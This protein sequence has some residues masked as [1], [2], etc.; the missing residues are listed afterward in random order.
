MWNIIQ[1]FPVDLMGEHVLGCLEFPDL[2][3][4][5]R[6]T[7]AE[8]ENDAISKL[9]PYCPPIKIRNKLQDQYKI[10]KW[11]NKNQCRLQSWSIYLPDDIP[12]LN[13]DLVNNIHVSINKPIR[14]L[15]EIKD[16]IKPEIGLKVNNLSVSKSQDKTMISHLG[17]HLPNVQ[18]LKL[19]IYRHIDWLTKELFSSWKLEVISICTAPRYIHTVELR[20]DVDNAVTTIAQN[21]PHLQ[22]LFLRNVP[23]TYTSLLALSEFKLPLQ[24]LYIF[25]NIPT[26]PSTDILQGCAYALSR[27]RE[28]NTSSLQGI[29][30][31]PDAAVQ[32]FPNLHTLILATYSYPHHQA[33]MSALQFT[34]LMCLVVQ[35]G[36]VTTSD[37][38]AQCRGNPSLKRL[39]VFRSM[40]ITDI[41][42]VALVQ[43]CPQPQYICF[44]FETA[45]TDTGL[46][47]LPE[48][49]PHLQELDVSHCHQVTEAAVLQLLKRCRKL[50]CLA[51]PNRNLSK[52]TIQLLQCKYCKKQ[53]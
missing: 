10:I 17:S 28:L 11:V 48:H 19:E 51:V 40:C 7:V 39:E 31:A 18:Y 50:T 38:L 36:V 6:A 15:N 47:A 5:E 43:A 25:P 1:N 44:M 32:Y 45:I 49:C 23:L 2:V 26:I 14:F 13:M 20:L 3:R 46:L 42:L 35:G 37:L 27:I 22:R 9:F 12:N 21:C 30:C 33:V 29:R 41:M 8:A 53:Q 4:L 34:Q 24:D 16:I 52:Q